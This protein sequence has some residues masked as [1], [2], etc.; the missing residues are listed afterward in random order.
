MRRAYIAGGILAALLASACSSES[1]DREPTD[2]GTFDNLT[3]LA[4]DVLKDKQVTLAEYQGAVNDTIKCLENN[5]FSIEDKRVNS[6]TGF[7]SFGTGHDVPLGSTE[8]PEIDRLEGECQQRSMPVQVAFLIQNLPSAEERAA[9]PGILNTCLEAAGFALEGRSPNEAIRA[10]QANVHD[11][12]R[13]AAQAC[14]RNYYDSI[15]NVSPQVAE[16]WKAF[17]P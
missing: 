13:G 4:R 10:A 3:P 16:A 2:L 1:G 11:P 17:K 6:R 9:A 5:G 12:R 15:V 8:N 7:V 14:A